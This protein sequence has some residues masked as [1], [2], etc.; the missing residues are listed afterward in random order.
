MLLVTL[1]V[2]GRGVIFLLTDM[3]GRRRRPAGYAGDDCYLTKMR[4][5]LVNMVIPNR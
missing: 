3:G 1:G 5:P 4:E 2:L